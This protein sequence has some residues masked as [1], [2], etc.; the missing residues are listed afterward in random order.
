MNTGERIAALRK[1]KGYSQ[2]YVAR[3]IGV[4]RQ[5]VHKWEKETSSP[6]TN[7]LI[8]LAQVL[9][10]TVE[11]IVNGNEKA[12]SAMTVHKKKLPKVRTYIIVIF[13]TALVT[14]IATVLYIA[15][16]PVSFDAGACGGGFATAVYDQYANQL[17]EDNYFYLTKDFKNTD[18]EVHSIS[19]VRESREVHYEGK[20]IYMSFDAEYTFSNHTTNTVKLQFM[21]ERKWIQNYDWRMII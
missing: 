18:I 12:A 7:N 16:A 11:Y 17:I 14:F 20:A 8:A 21:G 6:D 4:S 2:E 13:I 10:T 3:Q 15:N 1:E 19:P 5:A 9:D